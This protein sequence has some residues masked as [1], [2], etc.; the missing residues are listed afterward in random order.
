VRNADIRADG[1][2][3]EEGLEV[4]SVPIAVRQGDSFNSGD[5]TENTDLVV[6]VADQRWFF[7]EGA[8][9]ERAW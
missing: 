2:R 1:G 9:R 3:A 8:A 7:D 5:D 4:E 6:G